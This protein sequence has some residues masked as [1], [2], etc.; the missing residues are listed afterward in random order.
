M[1]LPRG[2]AARRTPAYVPPAASTTIARSLSFGTEEEPLA[3]A[4]VC[5]DSRIASLTPWSVLK[6]VEPGQF[7]LDQPGHAQRQRRPVHAN[8]QLTRPA[9]EADGRD[10]TS[11]P[12]TSTERIRAKRACRSRGQHG[13]SHRA[14]AWRLPLHGVMTLGEL[15]LRSGKGC[16]RNIDFFH[17]LNVGPVPPS[18]FAV[19]SCPLEHFHQSQVRAFVPAILLENPQVVA[20]C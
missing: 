18:G 16:R 6:Q 19:S 4:G 5:P 10:G 12:G 14:G 9:R 13:R 11:G 1:C 20:G 17:A 8:S 2:W 15:S 3:T 7:G